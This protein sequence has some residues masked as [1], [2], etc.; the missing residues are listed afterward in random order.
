MSNQ[1]VSPV[2][3]FIKWVGGKSKIV[4]LISGRL[5]DSI[6]IYYEPFVGG[7]YV[8]FHLAQKNRF[9]NAIIS[10]TNPELI[11]AYRV[12]QTNVHDLI[13]EL[14]NGSY[15]Y[16]K[17]T[18]INFRSLDVDSLSPVEKAARFIYLNKTCF[19]GLYRVNKSGGFNTP[20]GKFTN[21]KICDSDNLLAVHHYLKKVHILQ[22]D[23]KDACADVE[24][25]DAVYFDPP[26]IPLSVT[27]NFTSYTSDGFNL[28]DHRRLAKFFKECVKRKVRTVLSNSS[29]KLS[30]Q[31]YA[32]YDIDTITGSR[33]IGG[34]AS[35]RKSVKEI[36]V[37]A[38]PKS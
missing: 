28:D 34:P 1:K 13:R 17:D 18:F 2:R 24:K 8:L 23:F 9:K 21:P 30:Y 15:K 14:N 27:S 33:C 6:N 10:D 19:N 37:F 36:I 12:I 32:D 31:L 26:Y 7:G 16:D 35:Y 11:N 20:F 3:P 38:G 29:S 4:D 5:P 22:T 25:G